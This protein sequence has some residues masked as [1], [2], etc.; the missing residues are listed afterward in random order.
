MDVTYHVAL[1]CVVAD[2]GVAAGEAVECLSGNAAVMR[3]ALSRKPGCAGAIA[4]SRSGSPATG[5]F[6]DAKL[7]RKYDDV[8]NDLSAVKPNYPSSECS[9]KKRSI[10]LVA[11]GPRGSV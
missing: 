7:V 2:D 11:S 4:F 9:R 1:P 3:Q 6:G 10:S 8:P 5:E